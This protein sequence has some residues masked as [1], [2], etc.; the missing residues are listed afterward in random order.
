MTMTLE[1]MEKKLKANEENLK[2]LEQRVRVTEDI[3]AIHQL[4]RRYV[5]IVLIVLRRMP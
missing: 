4:Q 1:E 2:E 3:Q 5:M